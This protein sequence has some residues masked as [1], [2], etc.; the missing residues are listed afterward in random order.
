MRFSFKIVLGFSATFAALV[1]SHL[2][3]LRLPYFWDEAGYYVPAALDFYRS[4]LLIPKTT[5]PEGHPPLV[6]IYLGLAWRLFGYSAWTA[7]AAMT[8]IA[9]ATVASLYVLARRIANREIAAWS[10]LLLTLSPL[11][12]AQSTLV[13]LD[14]AARSSPPWRF[15]SSSAISSGFLH[16]QLPWLFSVRKPPLCCCPLFGFMRGE[17][18]V[19]SRQSVRRP[20]HPWHRSSCRSCRWRPGRF[21]T[22][23][24]RAIG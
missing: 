9:T 8:L 2:P 18:D 24:Q 1:L 10:A 13:H 15:C 16:W 7:R 17:E 4:C 5:L 22:T 6:M 20:L 21:I 23:M 11:F 19:D 14:L 12:F 3:L